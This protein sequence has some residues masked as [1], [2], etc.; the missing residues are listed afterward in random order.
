MSTRTAWDARVSGC[1]GDCFTL[2]SELSKNAS[3]WLC[4]TDTAGD[5]HSVPT[6]NVTMAV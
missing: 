3:P 5:E 6:T 4:N 1:L 2:M